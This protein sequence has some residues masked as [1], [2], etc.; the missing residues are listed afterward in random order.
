LRHSLERRNPGLLKVSNPLRRLR[1]RSGACSGSDFDPG[2]G[3]LRALK[4]LDSGYLRGTAGMTKWRPAAI[5][6]AMVNDMETRPGR[7][8]GHFVEFCKRLK[9]YG[10]YHAMAASLL[11]ECRQ[12]G[13]HEP[14]CRTFSPLAPLTGDYS[15]GIH[16]ETP[17]GC[18]HFPDGN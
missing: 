8:D 12:T 5:I 10:I 9:R 3:V 7:R 11:G 4:S 1:T 6:A 17:D 16:P 18:R 14:V 2:N 15:S 13:I